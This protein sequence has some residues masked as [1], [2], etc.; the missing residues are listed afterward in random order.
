[1][2]RSLHKKN[3]YREKKDGGM[4]HKQKRKGFKRKKNKQ[5]S[6]VKEGQMQDM[7]EFK[8][9][10]KRKPATGKV[11]INLGLFSFQWGNMEERNKFENKT[12]KQH[13]QQLS[14]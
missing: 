14:G 8:G 13:S 2:L 11:D 9:F 6:K 5:D 1:M 7:K 4:V 3:V 12:L 10:K